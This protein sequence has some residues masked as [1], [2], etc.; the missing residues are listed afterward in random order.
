MTR[1]NW[2][3][4]NRDERPFNICTT[5]A[6][7]RRLGALISSLDGKIDSSVRLA[8]EQMWQDIFQVFP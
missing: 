4:S 3:L 1:S 6:G 5:I 7:R 2:I 8:Q